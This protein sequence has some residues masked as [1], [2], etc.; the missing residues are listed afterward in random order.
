MRVSR[1]GLT[2]ACMIVV[3]AQAF[4][5]S[6][7]FV[8]A[9][10]YA[11]GSNGAN[12][13]ALVDVNGDGFADLVLATN[14]GVSVLLNNGDGTYGPSMTY[15]TGGPLSN[16]VAV[17]DVNNDGL[18]DIVVTNMCT[19]TSGC[20]G[21]S[22]LLNN[23]ASPGTFLSPEN[24]NT[25][26]LETGG[27]AVGDVNNDGN[28][29]L[30]LTS[31]CQPQT[32]AGGDLTL[33][34]GNGDGTF[35]AFTTLSD[36]KGPVAIGD[37]NGDGNLDLVTGAGVMLGNGDG[38]FQVA[39]PTVAGGAIA[40]VLADL[41]NDGKLDVVSA[42]P[43]GVA[44]QLGNGDGTIGTQRNYTTAGA[45]PVSV[46]IA[47]FNGDN[48]PDI[49]VANE[50]TAVTKGVCSATGSVG[51]LAGNGDG[52]FK[53]A[54]AFLS[55]G[56]SATSVAVADVD[57][58]GKTDVAV[59]NVCTTSTNC[60]V[61]STGVLINDYVTATTV[62]VTTS[63]TPVLLGQTV[64][65]MATVAG[66]AGGSGPPDGTEV[67]FFDGVNS[68][69]PGFTVSGV[70]TFT[71]SFSTAASHSV[72][73]F[74][75]GDTYHSASQGSVLEVVNKFSTSVAISSALNPSNYSQSV[76]FTAVVTGTGGVVPTGTVTFKNGSAF[77]ASGTL[78]GAG[79]VTGS[80]TL[81]PVGVN[82]ITATYNGDP[83]N[84][85][86][87]SA[88][89]PQTVNQDQISMTLSS[90]PNPSTAG[91]S[92]KFTATLTSNGKIP[93]G[94][95]VFSYNGSQI[96]TGT[97]AGT[98]G[99]ATLSTTTLPSGSDQVTATYSGTVDFSSASASI[100]Q[101]VN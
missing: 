29:D 99:V 45:N 89:L 33:L 65:F 47:D 22:V 48:Y 42:T 56:K 49:A 7:K 50:C 12:A 28:L 10:T 35:E 32:C 67:D 84:T 91:K 59:S 17:A 38:T 27:V 6:A 44:V 18:P 98:T 3:A 25:G 66:V 76:S 31:N 92:V 73:A 62:K 94:S 4:G 69:G 80:S 37:M 26:G 101:V 54:T 85:S 51:V 2:C 14:N 96:G 57:Q 88:V 97:I 8:S 52:T 61:G 19:E 21:V 13:V 41:N 81:L 68:L 71:T 87:V 77:V 55:G 63:Q 58:D 1:I 11:S 95:V 74:Y 93:T 53:A 82:S 86:S 39:I 100:V 15:A 83:S 16:A 30:V 90:S 24:Y 79:T 43:T 40:I 75:N 72:K 36:A 46:A 64:T 70:A 60:N 9:V 78:N 34:L 5:A 23:A 20:Y